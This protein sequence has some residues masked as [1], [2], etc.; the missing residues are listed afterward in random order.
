MCGIVGYIGNKQACPILLDGLKRLEYRGYDSAGISVFCDNNLT[1][2]KSVGKISGLADALKMK[3]PDGNVGIAHTRWATHGVPSEVNAHPHFDCSGRIAV[4]HNGIIENFSVLK[5]LLASEGHKFVSQTDSEVL[6]HLI[7]KYL[8]GKSL[9]EAVSLALHQVAGT[10]GIVVM[11]ADHPAELVAAKKGSPLVIGVGS[12]EY[13]IA[14]DS[15]AIVAHTKHVIYL[16]DNEIATITLAGHQVANLTDASGI[17]KRVEEISWD[18]EQIEKGGFETFMLKEIFE[19]PQSIA[20]ALRGRILIEAGK[21]KI[22][23]LDEIKERLKNIKR[24]IIIGCGTSWHASLIGEFLIE[25]LAKVPVEVE[26]ASEFRYRHPILDASCLVIA[27]S[28]S[29]E[30]ADTLAALQLAKAAGALTFGICNVVGSSIARLVD[31]GIYLHAGPEI[32]V[33]STKAFT[34]QLSILT[35]L[36]VYLAAEKK[37]LTAEALKDILKNIE[38][39]PAAVEMVLRQN[40]NVRE[41]AEKLRF[42][43][44]FIYLGRG[45]N[46]P[47]ALEGAL[48][49]KEISYIHAEGYPAAEM[50]HGPIALVDSNMPVVFIATRD[51]TYDKVVSNILEVKA[52]GGIVIAIASEGDEEIAKIAQAVIYVP[53]TLDILTPI[54]NVIPLQLLAYHIARFKGCDVDKPRNLA[55]SVTVE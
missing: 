8:P 34:S 11:S 25:E 43:P 52:R 44:N 27:I 35:L 51:S 5:K 15:S 4:V 22:G 3:S 33:A 10:Y 54:V 42:A 31:A 7:E 32:G 47:V 38:A 21:I 14:S 36:A 23:G 9:T 49:L 12:G 24:I 40:E 53:K 19:Q 37:N 26:Y 1:T 55:K 50:K 30:T 20:N 16:D 18:L 41:L 45:N 17:V 6:A 2:V 13:L 28:Q 39:L 48:K 29:G 46:Y